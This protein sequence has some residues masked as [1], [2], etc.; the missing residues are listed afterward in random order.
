[1]QRVS[2]LFF[3]V[4]SVSVFLLTACDN[5]DVRAAQEAQVR[6]AQLQ[7][8]RRIASEQAIQ[9]QI[10]EQA[11]QRLGESQRRDQE[12]G[13]KTVSVDDVLLDGRELAQRRQKVIITG[14]YTNRFG[15]EFL[16]KE[17]LQALHAAGD[18]IPLLTNSANR[19][20]RE[21]ILNCRRMI[22]S[23]AHACGAWTLRGTIIPCFQ[24]TL[25]G[26]RED[27]CLS[28]DGF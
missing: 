24:R 4:M 10:D 22:A 7:E 19:S 21:M 12:Q 15:S 27:I 9:R 6:A 2:Y 11:L 26:I 1:M 5:R 14:Y 25:V 28:V 8:S 13:F 23:G 3:I 17:F 18:G 16:F 20:S